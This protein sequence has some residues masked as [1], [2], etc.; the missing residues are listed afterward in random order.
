MSV[1][2]D[3][4]DYTDYMDNAMRSA[5]NQYIAMSRV[6]EGVQFTDLGGFAFFRGI[7]RIAE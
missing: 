5:W 1:K 7:Q 6:V 4:T 2:I 3:T